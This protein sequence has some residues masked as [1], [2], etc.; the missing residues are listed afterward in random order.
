MIKFNLTQGLFDN[1]N[2]NKENNSF[3]L[4]S[5]N[6][7]SLTLPI[8]QDENSRITSDKKEDEITPIVHNNFVQQAYNDGKKSINFSRPL[9]KNE[10]IREILQNFKKT[11]TM[12]SNEISLNP[13]KK[14]KKHPGRK[15]KIKKNYGIESSEI[16]NFL[17]RKTV[18]RGEINF[19]TLEE[20]KNISENFHENNLDLIDNKNDK[21]ILLQNH[22][23]ECGRNS[24]IKST[25]SVRILPPQMNIKTKTKFSKAE[26]SISSA[27]ENNFT[28]STSSQLKIIFN[29]SILKLTVKIHEGRLKFLNEITIQR[30]L[31]IGE[32][33]KLM[34][35]IEKNEIIPFYKN[36]NSRNS[37]A[38][39]SQHETSPSPSLNSSLICSFSIC[40]FHTSAEEVFNLLS[41]LKV[42]ENY[43][44]LSNKLKN[45]H[46]L[47]LIDNKKFYSEFNC[48]NKDFQHEPEAEYS[49]ISVRDEII[50]DKLKIFKPFDIAI[51]V[52]KKFSQREE[53]VYK[54]LL[55][56]SSNPPKEVREMK[57]LFLDLYKQTDKDTERIINL[58]YENRKFYHRLKEI[59]R[60]YEI[61][62]KDKINLSKNLERNFEDFQVLKSQVQEK[63]NLL[64]ER[65]NEKKVVQEK[66]KYLEEKYNSTVDYLEGYII[67][68]KSKIT[69]KNDEGDILS[70]SNIKESKSYSPTISE[71]QI[72]EELML[73]ISCY[74]KN[75]ETV[76]I[77]CG[78][79]AYCIDCCLKVD[80][81]NV[82]STHIQFTSTEVKK[83]VRWANLNNYINVNTGSSSKSLI[84]KN[85]VNKCQID[86]PFCRTVNNKYMKVYFN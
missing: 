44:V 68:S 62:E 35:F 59:E 65:E 34:K 55:L 50:S 82:P 29:S 73:C 47:I 13:E 71:K 30:F 75:R 17:N 43:A 14:L 5:L 12:L 16:V 76:F 3:T 40:S 24:K 31:P 51:L 11:S 22:N 23:L 42:E 61:L 20:R 66:L 54:N 69:P 48:D 9:N 72:R 21:I 86:C 37:Q 26:I 79:S 70:K 67:E 28:L 46:S 45:R 84:K 18:S 80:R 36:C 8:Q 57:S 25:K 53:T 81:L 10:K 60:G 4:N 77:N 6:S 27:L 64:S 7:L 2:S 85:L 49:I 1:Q 41:N 38:Q 56:N 52:D 63:S 83:K 32:N 58:T 19:H 33:I 74:E 15:K 78:H 39:E